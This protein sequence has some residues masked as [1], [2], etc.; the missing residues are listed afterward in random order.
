MEQLGI[1]RMAKE[2]GLSG[3]GAVKNFGLLVAAALGFD[4]VIFLDDDEEVEDPTFLRRA[5]YGLGK[6]T[7][8]GV[9]I[10]AKTGLFIPESLSENKKIYN[11]AKSSLDKRLASASFNAFTPS[12]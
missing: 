12:S 4:S 3:Y 5:V 2:M 7:R 8:R 6:L 1:G 9:P 10:L 11:S